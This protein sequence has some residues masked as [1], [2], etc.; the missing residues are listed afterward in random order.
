LAFGVL[1]KHVIAQPVPAH[2][3]LAAHGAGQRGSLQVRHFCVD[4]LMRPLFRRASFINQRHGNAV[5]KMI[6]LLKFSQNFYEFENENR[7]FVAA[8]SEVSGQSRH[9]QTVNIP[10]KMMIKKF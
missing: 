1:L 4:L 9:H 5:I 10:I 7:R 6:F 2:K 3:L 8:L